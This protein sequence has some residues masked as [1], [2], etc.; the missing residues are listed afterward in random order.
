MPWPLRMIMYAS[1]IQLVILIY[2]GIRYFFHL[3]SMETSSFRLP[4]L[5]FF[6][7]AFLFLLYPILGYLQFKW[8]GSFSRTGYPHLLI[9]LFWFGVVY[10]GTM[11]TWLIAL[12]LTYLL[13]GLVFKSKKKSLKPVFAKIF[14]C[15]AAIV[16]VYTG[17]KMIWDTH[18]IV[19]EEITYTMPD[20]DRLSEPLTIVHIAD[21][22][23]DEFTDEKKMRRYTDKVNEAE[24]DIVIFAGDL[25]TSGRDHIQAGAEALGMIQS[26]HG[27]YAVVGDHDYWTDQE[28]IADAMAN[29]GVRMLRDENEWI[30]HHGS[31]IKITGVTELYSRQVP[32]DTLTA[33]LHETRS[34]LLS[35][36]ASHQASDRLINYAQDYGVHQLL[37]GHTHGGQIRISVFFYPVTAARAETPYVNGHWNLDQL[38]LNIN[39][40]LGF[41]LS[42]IRYNAPAQVSVIKVK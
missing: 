17:G 42:P 21:L 19:L 36:L 26:T 41:T 16:L 14:F 6:V 1:A 40:G 12:D 34:E 30:L 24:P 11:L 7:P 15:I 38:L 4:L 2:F 27:V 9:Y 25:I 5:G 31:Q 32:R 10:A 22:H 18:R 23:A 29:R 28:Y 39:N 3:K 35:I 13:S 20:D 8:F 37:A 33:L